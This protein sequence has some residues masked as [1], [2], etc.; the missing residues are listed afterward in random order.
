MKTKFCKILTTLLALCALVGCED[1]RKTVIPQGSTA[2][3]PTKFEIK[4]VDGVW[5]LYKGASEF[6]INGAAANRF[7]GDVKKWGGNVVRTYSTNANTKAILDEAWEQGLYVN[8]GLSMKNSDGFDYGDAANA[9]VIAKQ[10]EDHRTW[11]RRYKNHPAV[12]CWSIGNEAETG[13][14]TTNASLFKAVEDVAKMIHEEDP[15]HPTTITFANSDVN[16][17]IKVLMQHAPSI[18][19]LSVNSYYPNVGNVAKNTASAGWNKPWM[20][21][22]FGPRGTWAMSA[23]SDPKELSWGCLEEMTSTEKAELYGKVWRE[24]IK[25]N[26]SKGCIGSF[27]FVWGYQ[28]H[29]EVLTWYGLFDKERNTF[30]G[31]DVISECWTSKPVSKPAPRI[32][33][34]SKMTLNG[35][36]SGAGVSVV[37][38]STGNTATV[39]ATSP[40]GAPITYRWLINKEGEALADGS[41]P[42]GIEG[43]IEDNT[44]P[45]ITFKA[46]SIK[47][48]YRL[49]VFVTDEQ[50]HKVA[51]ACIPFLVKES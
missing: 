50:N 13:N 27:I 48:G 44:K 21:T 45:T 23:S 43:L 34:R 38:N 16:S 39:D 15:N 31:V 49:Y 19:I 25:S 22:E 42:D 2:Q 11:V 51:L 36:T 5:K 20:I 47:G 29:G 24:N 6:Y 3:R 40:S 18:D 7:Y 9:E 14:A 30:G 32:E 28:T 17:R 46:P 35:K 37:K 26:E 8:M 10:L 12:M 4:K 41:M 1:E 33:N